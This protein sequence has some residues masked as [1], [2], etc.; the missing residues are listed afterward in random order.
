MY[1]KLLPAALTMALLP[2][3]ASMA[4][5]GGGSDV[6]V[7]TRDFVVTTTDFERYLTERGLTGE[8][9]A[10]ALSKPGAVKNT[11]EN[12]YV[13]RAFAADAQRN[14][15]IDKEE[16]D[17]LVRHYRERLLMDRQL[18]LLVA[19]RLKTKDWEAL[20]REEYT[21]NRDA[22]KTT[23]RIDAAHI[24]VA[25]EE[26]TEDEALARAREVLSRLESGEDFTALAKEYSD[27]SNSAGKGGELGSFGR[28]RMVKPF[29]EAVFALSEPGAISAPVKTRYGYHIIRLNEHRPARQLSFEQASKQII[30]RLR[31]QAEQSARAEEIRP[32]KRGDTDLGLEVN[33]PLLQEIEQ[34]YPPAEDPGPRK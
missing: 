23:E 32:V 11:F 6:V 29:E 20:A 24:L 18:D 15:A 9:R 34:R 4:D 12:L 33:L 3:A 2:A 1:S 17:W 21:A 26:R 22:Y 14:P 13:L 28:G 5:A 19:S 30:P 16:I 31:K 8:R 27:D 10:Q 7:T 25:F